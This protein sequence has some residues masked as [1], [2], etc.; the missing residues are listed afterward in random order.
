MG[1]A[2]PSLW[3]NHLNDTTPLAD[4]GSPEIIGFRLAPMVGKAACLARDRCHRVGDPLDWP[5][6]QPT[7]DLGKVALVGRGQ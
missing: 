6:V 3:R 2:S 5:E 1:A 7:D 4:D